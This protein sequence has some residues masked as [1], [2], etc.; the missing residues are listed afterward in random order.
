MKRKQRYIQDKENQVVVVVFLYNIH[1]IKKRRKQKKQKRRKIII[2]LECAIR[3][4]L[5][6][7][8]LVLVDLF[9]ELGRNAAKPIAGKAKL[10]VRL[11]GECCWW[12]FCFG[13]ELDDVGD[14][15]D[16]HDV[17]VSVDPLRIW[18]VGI[19]RALFAANRTAAAAK[20]FVEGITGLI[21]GWFGG[22]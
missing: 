7:Y 17:T 14:E 3:I 8:V 2:R 6:L 16:E 12:W 9:T 18:E 11:V 5:V 19:V 13:D 15:A 22:V 4:Q 1:W 21:I 10:I 20:E